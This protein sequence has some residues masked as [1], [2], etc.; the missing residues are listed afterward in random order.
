MILAWLHIVFHNSNVL[1]S[2]YWVSFNPIFVRNS[3]FSQITSSWVHIGLHLYTD[4]FSSFYLNRVFLKSFQLDQ[5]V[6]LLELWSLHTLLWQY[7]GF[8]WPIYPRNHI[9]K[10]YN[11]TRPGFQIDSSSSIS[12]SIIASSHSIGFSQE[13]SNSLFQS[14]LYS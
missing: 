2:S 11:D 8:L 5:Q 3:E 10:I 13:A 1:S 9:N 12:L 6:D 14:H 4:H 7:L